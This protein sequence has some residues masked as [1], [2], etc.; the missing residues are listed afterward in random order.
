MRATPPA[1]KPFGALALLA[2]L[3]FVGCS[4]MPADDL[5]EFATAADRQNAAADASPDAVDATATDAADVAVPDAD[6]GGSDVADAIGPDALDADAADAQEIAGEDADAAVEVEDVADVQDAV[7]VA[8]AVPDG[9]L[10]EVAGPGD[11][12][13]VDA[14]PDAT[15]AVDTSVADAKD[16][17]ATDAVSDVQPAD[18]D[19]AQADEVGGED[20]PVVPPVDAT[21]AD[22]AV[23]AASDA[24]ADV[25]PSCVPADCNDGNSCTSDACDG[26]GK[27][28]HTAQAGP[29]EDGNSCTTGDAC[30]GKTCVG[31]TAV[32]CDDG[33]SCTSDTCAPASGCVHT[34]SAGACSD[35]DACTSGDK[36]AGG[37][38]AG[39]AKV[40]ASD[41]NPCT[42]DV[43]QA[44]ACVNDP[45]A[46]GTSCGIGLSCSATQT[47]AQND[48]VAMVSFTGGTFQM[49]SP[50]GQGG[51][52]EN[53]QHFVT[54]GSF[55]LDKT[56]VTIAQYGAFYS[57]LAVGQQCSA[58]NGTEFSCG[59]PDTSAGCNWG[60]SGLESQ[61][62]NCVDWQQASAYCAWAGKRLPTEAEWEFAARSGGLDQIWPWGSATVDC[63]L[64]MFDDG[65]GSGC[66]TGATAQP[67]S[68]SAG[69]SA[70]GVCDLAGNVAEW[71]ADWYDLYSDVTQTNP[72]GPA[73]SP[74]GTRAVRGGSW[75]D[76]AQF[77]RAVA[78]ASALPTART[79]PTGF[80]CAK[81]P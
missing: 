19:A 80:R 79:A 44:G 58:A 15:V 69:N 4:K 76:T 40:C 52:N 53:P 35:G 63:S 72:M 50:V 60:V 64:A 68:K 18:A 32:P 74:D 81:T 2:L 1:S 30:S 59:Q 54:V 6:S 22:A 14:A 25:A 73:S 17:T 51:S 10:D 9:Q 34:P 48:A 47:C 49:G 23:D 70:Q 71:C 46:V 39:I 55:A 56:E 37:A 38:C 21:A 24:S 77:L 57:A 13:A 43:C 12:T 36:C 28:L 3:L 29:C 45:V 33:N 27:C 5:F 78:R 8:D 75:S 67:C 61:P 16:A 41:G 31:G 62:A 66:G 11:A 26:S 42:N 7:D 20:A 65:G